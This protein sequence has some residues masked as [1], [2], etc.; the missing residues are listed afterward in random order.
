M[1]SI[2][3]PRLKPWAKRN[4][5]W[6]IHLFQEIMSHSF[7]KI[8]IHAIWSTKERRRM[9]KPEI[10]P[11]I[12][13]QMAQQFMESG[14][15]VKIIN[16]MPDH[17]HSLFLLNPQ[18]CITDIIK[19]VKGGTSHWIN[20]GNMIPEKFAWQTGFA[21]YSVSESQLGKVY[22]YILHQKEHHKKKSFTEEYDEFIKLHGF[23][24]EEAL[25]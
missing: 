7:I 5:R 23:I 3:Y 4:K 18:R 24:N 2:R 10:E 9:I 1:P 25:K 13:E 20:A 16:G 6:L 14:C 15:P 8:W 19:Q 12:Y 11:L 22:P 21:A 17:A